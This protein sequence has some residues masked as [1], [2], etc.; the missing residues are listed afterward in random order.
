MDVLAIFWQPLIFSICFNLP[1]PILK[2]GVGGVSGST[3]NWKYGLWIRGWHDVNHRGKSHFDIFCVAHKLCDTFS[4]WQANHT[5]SSYQSNYS[6][7]ACL[8]YKLIFSSHSL[9]STQAMNVGRFGGFWKC[10]SW[11]N[12]T[13]QYCASKCPVGYDNIVAHGKLEMLTCRY[14]N[15]T[16]LMIAFKQKRH[17]YVRT[18]TKANRVAERKKLNNE[19][20]WL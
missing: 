7:L 1:I 14:R 2:G 12:I 4:T 18:S 19:P 11:T 9:F 15:I 10:S 5:L 13:D 8:V 6:Y 17:L 3:D 20:R 16:I